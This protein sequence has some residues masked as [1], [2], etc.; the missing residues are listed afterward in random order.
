MRRPNI[1]FI[2]ADD[3]GFW[4]LGSAGNRDAVTPNLD[5]MAREGCIAENFFCSSPV[6]SPAR[7]TLLTG[8]MPS[9]HGI[10]DWILRGNI[11]NEGEIPIEYLNDFKG[12]RIYMRIERQMASR[13]QSKTTKRFLA[14]VCA[15]VGR[16]ELL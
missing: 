14:L 12:S 16:R 1:V 15:S 10:L 7:A 6:C 2:L 8:R 13:R 4:T 5:E 11:K 3:M 9:M